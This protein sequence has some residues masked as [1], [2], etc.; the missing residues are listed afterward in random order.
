LVVTR[1]APKATLKSERLRIQRRLSNSTLAF[2]MTEGTAA[3]D[4][5]AVFRQ[6]C[7]SRVTLRTQHISK[8]PEGTSQGEKPETAKKQTKPESK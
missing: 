3:E 4:F 2:W 5:Y 1:D 6:F 7:I 8:R